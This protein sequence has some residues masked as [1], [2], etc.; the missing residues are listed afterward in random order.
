[1]ASKRFFISHSSADKPFALEL[2]AALKNDAWVDLHEIE[3]GDI[4]LQEISAG[5]EAATD[6]V[7]LW[8]AHS[9]ASSWV[10]FEVHLAFIR[11][12]ED[13]AMNIHVVCLDATPPMLILKPFLQIRGS[14]TVD[15]VASSLLSPSVPP[16]PRRQFF[17]RNAEV[18]R[19][20]ASLYD[21]TIIGLFVCGVPGSGKRSLAR[22][23]LK[24]I[25]SGTT[26]VQFI[27][28]SAGVA[29]PELNLL[30]AGR[31]RTHPSPETTSI[32]D[33]VEHTATLL[34]SFTQAGGVWVFEE[35]QHWLNDDGTLGR[36]CK[37]ILAAVGPGNSAESQLTVFTSRRKPR[38]PDVESSVASFYL[39]G[40]SIQYSIALL[41]AH[42]AVGTAEELGAVANEVDGHPLALEVVAPQLPLDASKLRDQRHEIASDLIDP[43]SIMPVTWRLLE[44]LALG[45][46]PMLGEDLAYFLNE[47]TTGFQSA[48]AQAVEYS[49]VTLDEHGSLALHPLLRDYFF[50][51][52]RQQPD[53]QQQTE[54]VADVL[55]KRLDGLSQT[56]PLYTPVLLATVKVLGLAG[57]FDEAISLRRGLIGTLHETAQELYQDKRY[58]E[59]LQYVDEALTGDKEIDQNTLRL[60][61][62]TLAYLGRFPEARSIG[63][64]LVTSFPQSAAVMRDRGRIE[65]IARDW[66]RAIHYFQ[67]AIPLRHNS[68]QLWADIAQAKVRLKDWEGAAAAAK[69]AIDLGG[70]T[71]W[72]LAIYSQALEEQ[73]IYPEAEEMMA[74]AVQREPRNAEFRHRLGR[75]AI[76][77]GDR[78]K[79]IG[80]FRQ[81]LSLDPK[82]VQ[83]WLSL[84]SALADD[85]H[86]TGAKEALETGATIPGAPQAIVENVR[87]K[88]YFLL[89]EL[90]PANSMI[91]EALKHRRDPHNLALAIRIV[92]A[93][94]E[95]GAIPRGQAKARVK[96]LAIELD[97][98]DAL[99]LVLDYSSEFPAYFD[100]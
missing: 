6:F 57:R 86:P 81:S 76:Q 46:G 47:D 78:P 5:I 17:N 54:R 90:E 94:A 38:V 61:A 64:D 9:A 58:Q 32:P 26:T 22:E 99:R 21:S 36:I 66:P 41:R 1:M 95:Q 59:A 42:S 20:E 10:S 72:A 55:K 2:K 45:D 83:S 62:K 80:Q 79:A 87:A 44:L 7:I 52:F 71:P 51:S 29:E 19:I 4:L 30:V 23:A 25:T 8:S 60:K 97:A 27:P 65:F 75:I 14:Q 43:S 73:R 16:E 100:F 12:I 74:R 77:T 37:Q 92:I 67:R 28:V 63:D 24:R 69:T 11:R 3:S 56:D 48:V 98:Q 39:S 70:D 50:R 93:R 82:Y 53:H 35:A 84:A 31:L 88:I 13:N 49:L 15:D 96:T 89:G 33:I 18:E 34:R 68:S 85:G 91:E 40:L